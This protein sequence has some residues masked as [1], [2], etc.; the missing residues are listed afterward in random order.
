MTMKQV[1]GYAPRVTELARE[2][3]QLG[4][5][6]GCDGCRGMCPALVEALALPDAI[7]ARGGR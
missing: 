3:G 7:L 6:I 5:C 4:C 2:L 1:A